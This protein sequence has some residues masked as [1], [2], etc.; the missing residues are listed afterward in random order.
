M[1]PEPNRISPGGHVSR[2]MS[3]QAR[4]DIASELKLRRELHARGMRYCIQLPVPGLRRRRIDVAFT[5]VRL[6]VFVDGCFWH[7]CPLHGVQ[8]QANSDWWDWK[9]RRNAE[10]DSATNRIPV[11]AGWRVLRVWEHDFLLP[12]AQAVEDAVRNSAD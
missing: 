1:I 5:R 2:R 10:R 8:P 11:S 4:S 7:G 12:A 9:F 6:A 3:S